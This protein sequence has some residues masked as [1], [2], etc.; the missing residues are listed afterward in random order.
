MSKK[1]SDNESSKDYSDSEYRSESPFT[2]V[3]RRLVALMQPIGMTTTNIL[4]KKNAE[5]SKQVEKANMEERG[6]SRRRRGRTNQ[7]HDFSDIDDKGA[8]SPLSTK[9]SLSGPTF[10][11]APH[12]YSADP[13]TRPSGSERRRVQ[14]SPVDSVGT[15]EARAH[16]GSSGTQPYPRVEREK[17]RDPGALRGD[18]L[19]M[20]H[21]FQDQERWPTIGPIKDGEVIVVT[22]RYTYRPK[23]HPQ[24]TRECAQEPFQERVDRAPTGVDR[25]NMNFAAEHDSTN[26]YQNGWSHQTL[27]APEAPRRLR[28]RD[29]ESDFALPS[30][31]S[32]GISTQSRSQD[33]KSPLSL[34]STLTNVSFLAAKYHQPY[35]PRAPSPPQA[36]GR[37]SDIGSWINSARHSAPYPPSEEEG[38][39]RPR[40][41]SHLS[42]EGHRNGRGRR[43][44]NYR[45]P[46][47]RDATD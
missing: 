28:P 26:Y 31:S 37:S 15:S 42:S 36:G 29:L 44:S 34:R 10:I 41:G 4:Q 17:I 1:Y 46:T 20:E 16:Y 19:G 12:G 6:R 5:H 43:M 45:P 9:P 14:R 47:V 11:K 18:E 25:R 33:C 39:V 24:V 21:R 38:I 22:E 2:K 8:P 30:S 27:K 35:M 13:Y 40:N 7:Y 3:C 32:S 23:Q